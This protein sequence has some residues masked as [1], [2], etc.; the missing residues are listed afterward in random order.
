MASAR[1]RLKMMGCRVHSDSRFTN[2]SIIWGPHV[3]E[4]KR[5]PDRA[6]T[7]GSRSW[8]V[9]N[10][11]SAFASVGAT[12]HVPVNWILIRWLDEST[13]EVIREESPGHQWRSAARRWE[14]FLTGPLSE[15]GVAVPLP[16]QVIGAK[17]DKVTEA[18]RE[19]AIRRE[20]SLLL[21]LAD[22]NDN[23][24]FDLEAT[25]RMKRSRAGGSREEGRGLASLRD[26]RRNRSPRLEVQGRD[27]RRQGAG[28]ARCRQ[29]HRGCV[30]RRR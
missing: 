17:Y 29:G 12:E 14:K 8:L 5:F 9:A 4:K 28:S 15:D 25:A 26:R 2:R 24:A 11:H 20:A 1:Q 6:L 3:F 19:Q 13:T 27:V 7:R 23:E 16:G 21:D 22:Q 10:G 18:L 30:Y